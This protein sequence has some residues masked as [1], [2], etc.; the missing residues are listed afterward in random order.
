MIASD[1][2]TRDSYVINSFRIMDNGLSMSVF[3][4]ENEINKIIDANENS[5]RPNQLFMD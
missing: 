1:T 2:R 3:Q 5:T 4:T